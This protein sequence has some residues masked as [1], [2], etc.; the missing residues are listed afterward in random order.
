MPP[1]HREVG[2]LG[3]ECDFWQKV[4][5]QVFTIVPRIISTFLIKRA[6]HR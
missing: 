4:M 2:F 6:H 5:S 3:A 1:N